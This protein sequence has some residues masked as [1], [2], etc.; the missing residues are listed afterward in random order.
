MNALIN[1]YNFTNYDTTVT[2]GVTRP[3]SLNDYIGQDLIK[4]Q[5]RLKINLA[6]KNKIAMGHTLLLGFAGAGK[7][8]LAKI[9]A[10]EIG[11]NFHECMAANIKSPDDL[12]DLIDR[13]L[14]LNTVLFIDEIHALKKDV[15]EA[16]YTIMEDFKYFRKGPNGTTD[17]KYLYTFTVI[18]ATTHAGNLNQPFLERFGWKPTL[19]PYSLDEMTLLITKACRN[20]F[21]MEIPVDVAQS[22]AKIS[23]NTPRKAMHLLQN[24]Y[25]TADGSIFD[26]RRVSSDDLSLINLEKTIKSLELDP[27]IGLDRSSRHYLNVLCGE[28]GK[29]IGS[30]SLASMIN[31]QEI[32]LINMI[33][34]FLTQPEIEIPSPVSDELIIG[35]LVKVTRGGRV[36]T[37]SATAYLKIC[38]NLQ[39]NH[40]WF[41]GERFNVD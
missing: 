5:A 23:Q 2:N 35:P 32:N 31:Q 21:N 38:K 33:E 19:Q 30:R 16:L 29:P 6:R 4:E 36:P 11:S 8:T 15:Q 24:L 28:K 34:P 9:I 7:T 37:E 41:P 14:K 1:Q 25:D 20:R 12:F 10:S 40:G 3:L 13:N 39:K 22:L 17:V 26:H 27:I 18:G